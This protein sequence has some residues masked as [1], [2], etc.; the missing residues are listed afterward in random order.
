MDWQSTSSLQRSSSPVPRRLGDTKFRYKDLDPQQNEIRLLRIL[1]GLPDQS[2]KCEI[3]HTALDGERRYIA[4]S[5]A[6]GDAEDTCLIILNGFSFPVTRSLWGALHRLRSESL[7]IIVWADAAC[8]NQQ[9]S[10]ER[11]AQVG[12]MTGI[13]E[14]AYDVAIW[15]GPE[16]DGSSEAFDLISDTV[17]FPEMIEDNINSPSCPNRFGALVNLF[18]RDYWNRLWCVQEVFNAK[19]ITVYCG[20]SALPW[21]AYLDFRYLIQP[22]RDL[23]LRR[24]SSERVSSTRQLWWRVVCDMGPGRM[25]TPDHPTDLMEILL[26]CRH[27]LSAEPR[28]KIYAVLGL[29]TEHERSQFTVDYNVSVREIFTEV[30]YYIL[31]RTRSLDIICATIHYPYHSD[32]FSLPS[33]VPDWMARPAQGEIGPLKNVHYGFRAATGTEAQFSFS[34]RRST[35]NVAGIIIGRVR[36]CGMKVEALLSNDS[37]LMAFHHW[38][39]LLIGEFGYNIS[40]HEAFC[41]T[42][43]LDQAK[44]RWTPFEW[45]SWTYYSMARYTE[46]MLPAMPSDPLLVDFEREAPEMTDGLRLQLFD[47]FV[48]TSVGRRFMICEND[49]LCLGSGYATHRDLICVLLGCTTPVILRERKDHYT[50]VGDVYADGYMYGEAIEELNDGARQLQTF[51]LH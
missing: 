3:L 10:T 34:N 28:D 51:E 31:T 25:W 1:P 26:F 45:L 12:K 13:Y 17:R 7:A 40:K 30:V 22:Y 36:T 33:W 49:M 9:D 35:L 19:T 42:L 38:R 39:W 8:I 24:L 21:K 15:L 23:L 44:E 11:G 46:R 32:T 20:D 41:R 48:K 4:L 18:E 16:A 27:K 5:Y 47:Q 43:S 2:V 37:R 6:W 14:N 29:L 50:Y